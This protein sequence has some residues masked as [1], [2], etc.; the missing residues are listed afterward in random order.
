MKKQRKGNQGDPE[1][2]KWKNGS[3]DVPSITSLCSG[4]YLQI[5]CFVK[6]VTQNAK[7]FD[8]VSHN[9]K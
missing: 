3:I 9:V 1:K 6:D 5:T 7:I 4:Q 8:L 2:T